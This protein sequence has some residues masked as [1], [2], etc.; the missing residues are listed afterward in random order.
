MRRVVVALALLAQVD[1]ADCFRP[2]TSQIRRRGGGLARGGPHL[3]AEAAATPPVGKATISSSTVN[4]VKAI[5]GSGVLSLPV[6]I[7]AFS[8]AKSALVPAYVLLAF[9]GALSAYTFSF[10]ARVVEATGSQ[11]WGEAWSK[12]LGEK[13]A[14]LPSSF[15]AFLCFSASLQYT[16]V[17]AATVSVRA[18][19]HAQWPV[20]RT[21]N[22]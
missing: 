20:C 5:V 18:R 12:T 19:L 10:V 3:M 8:N 16:M 9:I 17:R 7:A 22:R 6:G 13:T 15:V 11:T 14:W 1:S 2:H 21:A 4:L